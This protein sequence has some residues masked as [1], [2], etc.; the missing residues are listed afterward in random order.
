VM[1]SI[2]CGVLAVALLFTFTGCSKQTPDSGSAPAPAE[3]TAAEAMPAS[4]PHP[5]PTAAGAVVDLAGIEKAEGGRTVAELFDDMEQLAGESVV[6]RGKVVKVNA[7]IMDR[8]WLHVRDGS[9]VEGRND[10]TVTT[11]GTPPSVGDTVLVSGTV[12][13]NKDFGMGYAYP[14]IVEDATVSVESS[15]SQ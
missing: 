9:G 2:P 10:V 7:G 15:A 4:P 12:A 5:T 14:M 13:L 11:T 8:N 1:K 6:F 3:Q